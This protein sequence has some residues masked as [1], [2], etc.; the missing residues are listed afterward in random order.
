MKKSMK[1][2]VYLA[3]AITCSSLLLAGNSHAQLVTGL[4]Y[5]ELS[6]DDVSLGILSGSIGYEFGD[7]S[8]GFS[9]TPEFRI[10]AGV[11]DDK[12]G[13]LKVEAEA[14]YGFVLR[15]QFGF[16]NGAYVFAAPS[17]S[18]MEIRVSAPGFSAKDDAWEFG[19]TAGIGYQFTDFTSVELEYGQFDDL[20][21]VGIAVRM[22]F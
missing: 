13:A 3:S 18:N 1:L 2:K 10:G 8:D 21:V 22:K 17:Y 16:A 11:Q 20:D 6:D 7:G 12:V 19:G 4:G 15:G 5:Q 14:L 9:L